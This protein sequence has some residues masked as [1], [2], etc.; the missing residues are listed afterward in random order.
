MFVKEQIYLMKKLLT[1][2]D[3]K[4]E[5]QRKKECIELIQQQSKNL[6]KENKWKTTIIQMLIENQNNKVDL[7]LN[8]TKKLKISHENQ[9]EI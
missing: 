8:S 3:N 2:T 4:S 9:T 5:P 7:E 6:K 1:K